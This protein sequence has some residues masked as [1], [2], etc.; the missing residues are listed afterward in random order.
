MLGF[1]LALSAGP[2]TGQSVPVVTGDARVDKLLSQM[3][4]NEKLTLIH[5]TDEDPAVYQGQAGYLGG[6]PRLGIPGLR[7]ADGP[8]GVL[9]RHPSQ[10]ETA[11]MGV[12]ATFSRKTAEENGLVIGREDR[13]LGIDVS[14]QPFVNIDRDL[15]FARGYNTF[16]ED[17]FLTSEMGVAEI[18]GIQ[19]QHVMSQVKHFVGYDSNGRSTYIDD[20]TLHEV[21]VAPFDAAVKAGVSSIMCSYN[22]LNGTYACGNQSTLT[23]ILR[24]E[25]GFK[26]FVTSDWGAVHAVNFINAGL[27]MEMPGEPFA[28]IKTWGIPTFF[29]LQPAYTPQ[30]KKAED[31]V[32]AFGGS[33]PE[34][35]IGQENA[36]DFGLSLDPR[37]M[38]E[39]L[40]DGTVNEATITRAAGYVLYEIDRF[41]YLDGLSK[42]EVTTQSIEANAKIME[43]TGEE[44]AVLLKNEGGALPLKAADLDSVVL[45][46]PTAGQVDSIGINGERSV[47]LTE[48][49]VGPYDALKKITGNANIRFAVD[50]DM[51]GT[52]VPASVLSHDGKPGLVR[53]GS[54]AEQID[55]QINFTGAHALAPNSTVTWKGTLTPT[56]AGVYWLYLQALGTNA[57]IFIGGKRL[58]TTGVEQG[59]VHGDILQANQDNVVPTTDGI[60]NV[61]QAVQL[62]AGENEIKIETTP[63]TSNSPVQVRLNWYTPEQRV[64]DHEAA[65]AAAKSAKVAVVFLWT[66]LEPVFGLPGEQDKLVEEVAAVNPNTIVV[67]NT[68]QPVALPWLDKVKAV[69]EMWWPGDEGGWSTANLLAGKS[70]PAGRL[71][72][73]WGKRLEDYAATDPKHPERSRKGVDGKTTYSEG[74]NVGYRW[75]DKEKIAPLFAFGHG[76]SYTTFEYSGLKVEKASGGGLYVKVNIKNSGKV[77]SDEVPQIYLG[78]PSVIPDGVQFPVRALV[79]F[80][81]VPLAAGEA[82]TVTLHVAPRQLQYWSTKDGKWVTASGKRTLSVGASSRDLRLETS[83]D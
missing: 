76:L 69:L 8:P 67:L 55:A 9:T 57:K 24:E 77:D 45:I 47:G 78:A 15:E 12:A 51:T 49:Q 20:Q 65:I 27:D 1:V 60:D 68:S 56:H 63:D 25:I 82:K 70:S 6:I 30:S 35:P 81:R 42:H 19:S 46:G 58:G 48:R 43:K 18:K 44:A 74:V 37:K 53:T 29:D 34:E 71:P 21:Y 22:R 59:G 3:T 61:R 2:A 33:I 28:H 26:G 73:T 75:F 31:N 39:A 54:G 41:G 10:G 38:T 4:L 40:K 16:G 17:P 5:G 36:N 52:L 32:D 72:V 83:I 11:T 7:F 66:R 50:D 80:D 14:L 23:K 64:A 13:A 62:A 79:G